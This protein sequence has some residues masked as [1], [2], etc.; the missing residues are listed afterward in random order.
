MPVTFNKTTQRWVADYTDAKGKRH[1]RGFDTKKGA[2]AHLLEVETMIQNGSFRSEAERMTVADLGRIYIDYSQKRVLIKEID[3]TTHCNY[4]AHIERYV[5]GSGDLWTSQKP[6]LAG[7]KFGYPLGHLKLKELRVAH[8]NQFID[9]LQG[10]ELSLSF[11]A[12]A[13]STLRRMLDLAIERDW[14]VHNV[15]KNAKRL[16]RRVDAS[17]TRDNDTDDEDDEDVFIPEK[18]EVAALCAASRV[19]TGPILR[20]AASTGLR[21]SEQRALAWRHV[22]LEKGTVRVRRRINRLGQFGQPKSLAGRRTVPL[23]EGLVAAMKEW[24][25]QSGFTGPDDLVFPNG[26][27]NPEGHSNW[28]QRLFQPAWARAQELNPELVDRPLWRWHDM[29]HFAISCWIE[30]DVPL[31]QIMKWAGHSS[32]QMTLDRYGHLFKSTDHSAAMQ[33]IESDIWLP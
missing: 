32:A 9:E 27:G 21:G 4:V 16:R 28:R 3:Q 8:V 14:L 13:T 6:E 20:F 12:G 25:Q 33:K 5:I 30:A 19:T 22:D 2:K 18:A 11:I 15:A 17:A 24:K 23:A 31:K 1:R 10:L 29:R 7:Q 26:V